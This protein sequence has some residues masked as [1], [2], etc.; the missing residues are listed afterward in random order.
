M[1]VG[2]LKQG[3]ALK[4]LVDV[5]LLGKNLFLNLCMSLAQTVFIRRCASG[6]E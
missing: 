2:L 3:F 4:S 5:E 6:S 1:V